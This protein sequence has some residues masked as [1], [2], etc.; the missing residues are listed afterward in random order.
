[1]RSYA[2]AWS[3]F[4]KSLSASTAAAVRVAVGVFAGA[5]HT[6]RRP[7]P[8]AATTITRAAPRSVPRST[9]SRIMVPSRARFG[10]FAPQFMPYINVV[11]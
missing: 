7:Q 4:Q 8:A 1:M 6:A 11:K 9:R 2:P 10:S 5:D 3:V